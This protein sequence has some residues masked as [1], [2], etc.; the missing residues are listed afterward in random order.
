MGTLPAFPKMDKENPCGSEAFR[1]SCAP[2]THQPFS[3]QREQESV[4]EITGGS[5]VGVGVAV[6][7]GV[8]VNVDVGVGVRVGVD[9]GVLEGGAGVGVSGSGSG[10]TQL[11]AS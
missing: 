3:P 11:Q 9:V 2:S 7:V 8:G 1:A 4:P 5:G 6:L 10:V